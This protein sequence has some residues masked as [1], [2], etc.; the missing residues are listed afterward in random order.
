MTSC[1]KQIDLGEQ[2]EN[3]DSY[4]FFCFASFEERCLSAIRALR[5]KEF[6]KTFIFQ[7]EEF[8]HTSDKNLNNLKILLPTYE[9]IELK[10]SLPM[11]SVDI[12][13]GII[14]ELKRLEIKN[15]LVDISCFN[16]EVLLILLNLLCSQKEQFTSIK[17]VYNSAGEMPLDL[18]FGLLDVRSI[19]GFGGLASPLKKDHIIVLLGFEYERA[20]QII[21]K[22]EPALVTITIGGKDQSISLDLHEKN[23]KALDNFNKLKNQIICPNNE[24]EIP[25]NS[26]RETMLA[27]QDI[28]RKN[29]Q[30]N[31]ILAPLNT[32]LSTIGAGMAAIL[33]SEVQICYSQ[34]A[35]YNFVNYSKPGDDFYICDI[36]TLFSSVTP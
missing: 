3:L 24:I 12:L 30:Y 5:Q 36:S 9:H 31:T 15:I 8:K 23:K 1:C 16:R 19:F 21:E 14:G 20:R 6:A 2:F 17:F 27:V 28:I 22:Y 34:M 13:V 4:A 10:N 29:S 35:D 32:K 7:F 33:S 18:S 26:P 11:M 25:I